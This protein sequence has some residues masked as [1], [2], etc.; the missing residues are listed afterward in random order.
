[1]H[2]RII[3]ALLGITLIAFGCSEERGTVPSAPEPQQEIGIDAEA[4]AWALVTEAAWPVEAS[5]EELGQAGVAQCH[6]ANIPFLFFERTP[7]TGDIVHYSLTVRT[8]PGQYDKIGLHRVVR[9]NSPYHLI[10]TDQA[11]FML[12][13]DLK[14]FEGMFIPGQ[15]SPHLPGDFGIAVYLAQN[16]V[17]V[18]GIDQGWNL[19]PAE[20]TN[21]LFFADWGIQREVDHLGIGLRIARIVRLVTGNGHDK[22]LLLGYSSGS[23]TGYALLNQEAQRPY[24]RR[25]VKGFI[26]A[27]LGVR[28]DDPDWIEMAQGGVE[29]YQYVYDSG[30]YE[31]PLIFRDVAFLAQTDPGGDSPYIPGFTNLQCALFFG[32][33]L[34]FGNTNAHYHAPILQSG[35]PVDFQFIT[36]D[37]WLDFIENTAAYEPILFELECFELLAM[38]DSPYIDHLGDITVPVFDLGG[39]GGIAPYTAATLSYLGSDDITQLYVSIGAPEVQ[40]EY[41]HI[42]IFTASNSPELVWQPVL[43]WIEDHSE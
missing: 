12:H 22:M 18:W 27:D 43:E 29:Y 34:V 38:L 26:A 4:L 17:D 1:M 15:F 8:G 10:R 5:E 40:L 28:S 41:G 13:G 16:D 14:D 36:V 32:G 39:A 19:V 25:Q 24:A 37:Q 21:F 33:G 3:F 30:Q 20:E 35:L 42:D 6:G 2:K 11:L 23:A 9:E 7:I 31:D